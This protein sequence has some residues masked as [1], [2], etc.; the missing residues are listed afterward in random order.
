MDKKS[1]HWLSLFIGNM[2]FSGASAEELSRV[3]TYSTYVLHGEEPEDDIQDL[4]DKYP[5]K[6]EK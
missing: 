5:I 6:P 3:I 4:I 2:V 1:R